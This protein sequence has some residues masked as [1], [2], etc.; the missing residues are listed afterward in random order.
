[1]PLWTN[2]YNG[3][4]NGDDSATSIAVDS[5]GNVF[6]T[7]NSYVCC[8]ECSRDGNWYATI[9]YSSAGVPLWTNRYTGPGN[10]GNYASA[11][12]LDSDGNV[13]VTGSSRGSGSSYDY[14][15][16]KYSGAGVPL[17]TN[18]Y[19]GLGNAWDQANAVALDS[20]GNVC[21]TGGSD[22]VGNSSAYVTIKYS[23][24]GVPLWTNRY[25]GPGNAWDGA[26]AM[27]LDNSGN[28]FVTGG[29]DGGGSAYDYATIKYSSAGLPLW[30]NRYNGSGNADDQATD[31]AV[32]GSGNIFVTGSSIGSGGS[33]DLCHH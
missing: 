1:M 5:S 20:N 28:V 30:T 11:V 27:A 31:I 33:Y 19:N 8:C 6:V 16:I 25:N 21:V 14:A 10:A 4:G 15:T 2:R 3:P 9:A 17:W 32:D 7:G 13:F 24:A 23:S 26:W 12:A 18:R 29:S 22:G